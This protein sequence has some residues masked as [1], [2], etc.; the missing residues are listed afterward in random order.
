MSESFRGEYYQKVDSKARML[1][2]ATFRRILERGDERTP[3]TPRT[4]VVIIYGGGRSREFCEIYTMQMAERLAAKV[5]RLKP[6]S[7]ARK[8]AERELLKRSVTVEIDDDGRVILPNQV[9]EKL[10]MAADELKDGVEACLAGVGNR[11]ELWRGDLY[12]EVNAPLPE[13][14]DEDTS[15]PLGL[16]ADDDEEF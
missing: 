13:E 4:R 9:R 10:G 2:P 8:R 14:E 11:L 1:I 16:L 5:R 12:R 6:G 3:D 15:D 7:E